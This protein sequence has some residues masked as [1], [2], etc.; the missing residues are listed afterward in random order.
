MWTKIL[1]PCVA[2]EIIFKAKTNCYVYCAG[3]CI[4]SCAGVSDPKVKRDTDLELSYATP[5]PV[6]MR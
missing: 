5:E 2:T 4:V 3:V 1:E 6:T